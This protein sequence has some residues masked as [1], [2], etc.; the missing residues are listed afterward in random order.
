MGRIPG[1]FSIDTVFWFLVEICALVLDCNVAGPGRDCAKTLTGD[2]WM[3][4]GGCVSTY[5]HCPSALCCLTCGFQKREHMGVDWFI[6]H[7]YLIIGLAMLLASCIYLYKYV[8]RENSSEAHSIFDYLFVWPFLIDQY[9]KN[10][11]KSSNRFVII[12]LLD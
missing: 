7:S 8:R 1:R 5:A 4:D 2:N 9:K 3:A 6:R 10:S 11:I 12:G